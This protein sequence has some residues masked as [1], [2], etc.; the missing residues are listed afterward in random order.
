MFDLVQVFSLSS[1]T[2]LNPRIIFKNKKF[3]N[4]KVGNGNDTHTHARTHPLTHSRTHNYKNFEEKFAKKK[5]IQIN[6]AVF[7][8]HGESFGEKQ[9]MIMMMIM[10]T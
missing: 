3:L 6:S 10:R 8:L 5:K 7:I 9:I 2:L 1:F 4:Q